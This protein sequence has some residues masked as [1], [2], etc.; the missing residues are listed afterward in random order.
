MFLK[1]LTFHLTLAGHVIHVMNE[2]ETVALKK[3]HLVKRFLLTLMTHLGLSI[4]ILPGYVIL[5]IIKPAILVQNSLQ[6]LVHLVL[7]GSV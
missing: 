6:T 3:L 5:A 1:M 7:V 2:A 4:L